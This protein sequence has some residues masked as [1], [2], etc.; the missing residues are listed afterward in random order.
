MVELSAFFPSS[1]FRLRSSLSW[2]GGSLD[3]EAPLYANEGGVAG[4]TLAASSTTEVD[5]SFRSAVKKGK[6]VGEKAMQRSNSIHN[7]EA[8]LDQR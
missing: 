5:D 2:D 6:G 4:E 3:G 1:F 8:K 7:I